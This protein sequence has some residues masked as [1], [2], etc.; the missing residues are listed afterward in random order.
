MTYIYKLGAL[1]LSI[2]NVLLTLLTLP[3]AGA[4]MLRS[5]IL[6]PAPLIAMHQARKQKTCLLLAWGG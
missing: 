5:I 4:R 6:W 1:M 3:T 2:K